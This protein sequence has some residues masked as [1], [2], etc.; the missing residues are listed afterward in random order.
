MVKRFYVYSLSDPRTLQVFYIGKGT[1][2]RRVAHSHKVK[3][4]ADDMTAKAVRV[5]EIIDAGHEVISTIIEKFEN[6]ADAYTAEQA[7]IDTV[8][9]ENL[10]NSNVGGGGDRARATKAGRALTPKQEAFARAYIETGNASQAY[11]DCY[12]VGENTKPETVWRKAQELL[13][14]GMVTARVAELQNRSLKRHDITIDSLTDRFEA[15]REL[16]MDT[17][18]PGAAVQATN[19]LAKVHGLLVERRQHE[20]GAAPVKVE[21]VT[22]VPR[23]PTD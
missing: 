7:L 11:R 15:A 16:A 12:D 1:A 4:K 5:R 22:G 18:Q 17:A 10:T 23:N 9:L 6:E 8:G 19:G 13:A 21:V 2:A 20:G 14:N 3:L